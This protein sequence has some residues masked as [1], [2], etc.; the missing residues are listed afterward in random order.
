MRI[1]K[2]EPFAEDRNFGGECNHYLAM[3]TIDG[4]YIEAPCNED[5]VPVSLPGHV[6]R[7]AARGRSALVNVSFGYAATCH[8]MQ[9]SQARRVT[10]LLFDGD[11]VKYKCGDDDYRRWVYTAY[12][13][14][15]EKLFIMWS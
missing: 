15:E 1:Y 6:L 8:K 14:A 13:R 4:V 5:G 10:T 7:K 11:W 3:E 9:G 2:H 12:T